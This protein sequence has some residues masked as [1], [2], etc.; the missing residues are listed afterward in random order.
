[1]VGMNLAEGIDERMYVCNPKDMNTTST[2]AAQVIWTRTNAR[3]YVV[4]AFTIGATVSLCGKRVGSAL[5]E[6]AQS[7]RCP[8][9]GVELI[10]TA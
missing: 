8:S 7:S 2:T 10:P 4:H 5:A 6:E 3:A 1:M 9:C